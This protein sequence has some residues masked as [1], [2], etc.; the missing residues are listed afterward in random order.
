VCVLWGEGA[1]DERREGG[2][3]SAV[4][5]CAA[6]DGARLP[7]EMLIAWRAD[8]APCRRRLGASLRLICI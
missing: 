7:G 2:E 5:R 3:R 4:G 1:V 8:T 6:T